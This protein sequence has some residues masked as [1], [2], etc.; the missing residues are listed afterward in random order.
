MGTSSSRVRSRVIDMSSM[1]ALESL[2]TFDSPFLSLTTSSTLTSQ[3]TL[4]HQETT[5][6]IPRNEVC[7]SRSTPLTGYEPNETDSS[8]PFFQLSSTTH[9]RPCPH[10]LR[11]TTHIRKTD[12]VEKKG[13]QV[14]SQF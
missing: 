14:Q 8:A 7:G 9:L 6:P 1:F 13:F 12:E 10:T 5:N 3:P 11:L 4:P 2:F